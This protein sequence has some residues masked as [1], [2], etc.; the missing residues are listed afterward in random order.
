[1]KTGRIYN[2]IKISFLIVIL[3]GGI[4]CKKPNEIP[5]IAAR[6]PG[7]NPYFPCYPK[8][9]WI[10]KDSLGNSTTIKVDDEYFEYRII[11]GDDTINEPY[12]LPR[13]NGD[14]Y[15]NE[16]KIIRVSGKL[17]YYYP[18]S[19][20]D[21]FEPVVLVNENDEFNTVILNYSKQTQTFVSRLNSLTVEGVFYDT[22]IVNKIIFS[23]VSK[24][25][26]ILRFFSKSVG[27]VQ[28]KVIYHQDSFPDTV[29]VKSLT[30]YKIFKN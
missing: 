27:L 21:I 16:K 6:V 18:Y 2:L 28:E 3:H 19:E 12:L 13:I 22:L 20:F 11:T 7:I 23:G 29:V 24:P 10:Y 25:N 5:N 30:D 17:Y 14:Y 26:P 9:F 15:F 8:S 4:S 1:M